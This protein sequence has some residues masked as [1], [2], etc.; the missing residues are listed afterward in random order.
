MDI[1]TGRGNLPVSLC[2]EN[3]KWNRSGY[4]LAYVKKKNKK[5]FDG[6]FV[7]QM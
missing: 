7:M 2:G 4:S 1:G 5:L 6:S 3:V